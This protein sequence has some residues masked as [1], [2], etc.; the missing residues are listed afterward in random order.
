MFSAATAAVKQAETLAKEIRSNEEAQKWAEQ[1][2]GYGANLQHL[3]T[4]AA[5]LFD[6]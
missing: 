4:A 1:V 6:M 2:K 3:S 5:H